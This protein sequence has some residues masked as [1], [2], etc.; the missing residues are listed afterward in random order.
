MLFSELYSA[1]YNTVADILKEAVDHP[2]Q[3]KEMKV[4][5]FN[6]GWNRDKLLVYC[7]VLMYFSTGFFYLYSKI[8][9]I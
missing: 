4:Y 2:L 6:H 7:P 1:Y 9:T 5:T 3:D 8:F